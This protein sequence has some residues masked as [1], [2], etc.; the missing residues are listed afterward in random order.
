MALFKVLRGDESN[1][2]ATLN[3]G[4][5]Y[6]CSDTGNFY[7]DWADDA[8]NLARTQVN[9]NYAGKLRYEDNS[10]FLEI[11]PHEIALKD[12][13]I[14]VDPSLTVEGAAADAKA[15]SN[16]IAAIP[17]DDWSQNDSTAADFIKN[18]P[19]G[20]EKTDTLTWDGNTDGK[21]G[22]AATADGANVTIYKVHEYIP[23]TEG[24]WVSFTISFLN[25]GK[26]MSLVKTSDDLSG[27]VE[28]FDHGARVGA[29]FIYISDGQEKF[30]TTEVLPAGVWFAKQAQDENNMVYV[31]SFTIRDCACFTSI[32][33]LDETYI[34]D[35]IARTS[36]IPEVPV[37]SVNGMTG[38]VVVEQVQ[39]DW[40]QNDSTAPDYVKNRLFYASDPII[41]EVL[42]KAT[43]DFSV[44]TFGGVTAGLHFFDTE[45]TLKA[46]CLY[47]VNWNGIV[48]E[49][50]SFESNGQVLLGDIS[51]VDAS[52]ASTGEPFA[53][54]NEGMYAWDC[55]VG[56][57]STQRTIS[58]TGYETTITQL[59][60]AYIDDSIKRL[61]T[62]RA[63]TGFAAE[64]F[65]GGTAESASGQCSHSE[66][67]VTTASGENSHAEGHATDAIGYAS[68]A[69]GY[70]TIASGK[71]SHA[72]GNGNGMSG[73]SITYAGAS[74]ECSHT[75]GYITTAYGYGSHAEGGYTI[76]NGSC[77][78]VQGKLNIK[79]EEDKYLHIVGNGHIDGIVAS[80]SSM[81]RSNA[82]TLDWN[83]IGWYQGGLQ[84][85]GNAQDDGAKSV[86]LEGDAIPVPS[87]AFVGQTIVVKA[88]DDTGK[89][90]EWEAV[91]MPE[92]VSIDPTLTIEGSAADAKAVG[93]ALQD[94]SANYVK[95]SEKAAANGVATLDASGKL[96]ESQ[97]P[98]YS[99]SEVGLGNVP[100][101]ATNDQTPTYTEASTLA[102][103]TSGEKLSVAF[104]K[105][106]KAITDLIS[107]IAN[108]SNPHAVTAEQAGAAPTS[109][110]STA[111]TYGKA[112]SSNYGHVKLSASTSS[113]SGASAGVAATP[114]A[115]KS[116]YDLASSKQDAITVSSVTGQTK[117]I[118]CGSTV[119]LA[120]LALEA[121]TYLVFGNAKFPSASSTSGKYVIQCCLSKSTTYNHNAS[122]AIPNNSAAASTLN[123]HGVFTLSS[124]GTIYL[125]GYHGGDSTIT[126]ENINLYAVKIG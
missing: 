89:P 123:P 87:T 43:L 9:A 117:A 115:V 44:Q 101:V 114:S 92:S 77:Q 15:V 64:V 54:L 23:I 32:K 25:A 65:N 11:D 82:H 71:Y 13:L 85:G 90:T 1:L 95:S 61:A 48:Y 12:D 20:E 116:A 112:T 34:P 102:T 125:L 108:T 18:K 19:F 119:T 67:F 45:I 30:N 49:V 122:M 42:H 33:T 121:G 2:P 99:A 55:V 21:E 103:L 109:H 80:D 39:A 83:G 60:A 51:T 50:Y 68:H 16:A 118:T 14:Q 59:P 84:V 58:I 37:T 27:M 41:T 120:S 104:G 75:E 74:G 35:T 46:G 78:H 110:A 96:Q 10:S 124:A 3:D 79:D 105:I 97:K 98:S 111:T 40:N 88:V 93:E 31:S 26:L 62:H 94:V 107:H 72:E 29:G 66:G 38:D 81:V 24:A 4:W 56:E 86:L 7:I 53:I 76:A 8:G 126:V 69:E 100:N 6:F 91:D 28:L 5:A 17:Q 73:S 63:G 113:T 106:K 22:I 52:F 57:T 36:D 70:L 47:K